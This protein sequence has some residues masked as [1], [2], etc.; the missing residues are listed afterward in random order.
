MIISALLLTDSAV[1]KIGDFGLATVRSETRPVKTLGKHEDLE[2]Q[3]LETLTSE[4][5]TPIYSAPEITSRKYN[6]KVDIY[7]LGI[8]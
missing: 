2:D 5:G 8:W 4:I 7:S 1:A 3:S 6:H